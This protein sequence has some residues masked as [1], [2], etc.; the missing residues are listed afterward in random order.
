L[1]HLWESCSAVIRDWVCREYQKYWQFIPGQKHMKA[2]IARPFAK[3]TAEYLKLSR[4][5][6]D[7]RQDY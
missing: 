6:Q 2:F 1:W 3:R 7:K 4:F 5:K